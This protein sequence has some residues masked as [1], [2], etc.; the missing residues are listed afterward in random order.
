MVRGWFITFEGGEGTGKSTQL[1][2]LQQWLESR[3]AQVMVTR[4]PGGTRLAEGIRALLLDPCQE[5][6]GLSELF[7]LAA[8]RRDHVV[9][10]IE[11]ALARGEVVLCDRFADS[12][13]VYQG[14]VRK[15]GE[16]VT[17][18]VNQLAT[19]G[20]EPDL[21]IVL[22]MDPE[23]AVTR[24][25]LRNADRDD[26]QSRL[27]DEPDDF[28]RQIAAGY[29]RLAEL[30]PHRARMVDA[31]ADKETVFERLLVHLPKELR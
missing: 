12:S 25:R 22:D 16:E 10:V 1:R 7:L 2:L 30:L 29:R 27:D 11:P 18:Q 4:E 23:V 3:G 24:A 8:A 20:L 9:Q 5:P 21:T 28:H 31:A 26:A 14:M 6:D 15:V 13:L 19:G 17:G